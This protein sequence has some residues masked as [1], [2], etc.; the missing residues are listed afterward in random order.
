MADSCRDE[1]RGQH[2]LSAS[3]FTRGGIERLFALARR[4]KRIANGEIECTVLQKQMLGSF[5]WQESTRTRLSSERAFR[6]L[7]GEVCTFT[8][9]RFSS[10]VKGEDIPDT[11]QVLS[12]F[13]EIMVVRHPET[14]AVAEGAKFSRKPVISAGD[15]KG[16]HPTQGLL[17]VF[18]FQEALHGVDG[19]TVTAVGDLRDSR[20][21]HS[22]GLLLG[23]YDGVT[24]TCVAPPELQLPNEFVRKYRENSKGRLTIRT[25]ESLEDGIAD[26][27]AIY[28]IRPQQEHKDEDQQALVVEMYRQLCLTRDKI[29]RCCRKQHVI[30]THPLPR[31][32]E[33]SRDVD[34]LSGALYLTDQIDNGILVRMALFLLVLGKEEK[35]V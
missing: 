17:D 34:S 24:L 26:A 6:M 28:M 35:F 21:V 20:T 12:H 16:E 30:V 25:V 29:K 32:R 5:F 19:I 8:D 10:V 15:G 11:Y 1:F 7:G 23:L 33:I 2:I 31:N 13:C 22:L 4:M 27:D 3:Q 18:T 14:G 9:M